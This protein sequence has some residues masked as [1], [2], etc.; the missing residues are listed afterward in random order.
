MRLVLGVSGGI[1]AYKAAYLTSRLVQQGYDVQV[2][3][4]QA[5]T[6]FVQPLTF[7]AL[8]QR[9][10]GLFSQADPV[11][12]MSH[13]A[14]A[15][16][17]DALL[18]APVTANLLS[19]LA[20]GRGDD[21]LSLVYLGFSGPRLFAPAMEPEMWSH[22]AVVRNVKQLTL[23]GVQWV[24]P[25][26]GRMASGFHGQGR[27]AEPDE[28][29][30]ALVGLNTPKDL[31]GRRVLITA[32]ATYEYFDPVRLLTNPSTGTMG[33]TLARHALRRG[34]TVDL[35]VGPTVKSLGR[36]L[37]QARLKRVVSADD[38]LQ[39]CLSWLPQADFVVAAAA[40]SD[41]KP[42]VVLSDKAH[43]ED[44]A[45]TW[46]MERTADIVSELVR[47]KRR[48]TRI[49]GFAAETDRLVE[50]GQRKL[51]DKGLDW[52]VANAVGAEQ[53]FADFPYRATILGQ[54]GVEEIVEG[55]E[56]TAQAILNR[57]AKVDIEG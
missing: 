27:L 37:D 45:L 44:I 17:A 24:G 55:K 49:I 47:K 10:V 29:I 12:P 9:P 51:R 30:D 56:A 13:V 36:G 4:S 52:I 33:L 28:I 53:G 16:W 57:L 32:G 40:V 43:K 46:Q 38:M 25:N 22:P 6:E 11:G 48:G 39:A 14:L 42:K 19:R 31:L 2:I 41:F 15:H 18:Y 23:D 35:V 21:L 26:Y 1:A 54:G 7:S 8:T 3:M 34:A 20:V 50:S 5:A